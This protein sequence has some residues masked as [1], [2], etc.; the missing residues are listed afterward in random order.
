MKTWVYIDHFKGQAM[1]ASWEA[2]GAGKNL[3]TVTAVIFGQNVEALAKEAFENGAD[4]V[5]LADDVTLADYRAEAFSSSLSKLAAAAS[6]D[7]IFLPTTTRGRE[8]AAMAAIDLKTGV[9]VDV[10]AI[11][12]QGDSIVVTRPIYAGKLL[13]KETCSTRPQ[14]VTLRGRAFPKPATQAGRTSTLTKVSPAMSEADI[15]SKVEG[16]TTAEAGVS[17][18]DASV[19]VSGGRGVS[20]NPAL[21][22]PGGLDEKQT[23]IWRA[24]Q[25]FALVK[26]L[27]SVLGAAV[28]ASRA[29]V[30]AGYVTYSHQVGQTGKVVS[31]DL[32][33]A[34]GISGAIQHLAGMRTSKVIVAVNKDTDA[35]IFK[36]AR[37][38]VVGDL[39][40]ILPALTA[41]FKQRL[42]K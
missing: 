21:T 24:Q 3:G 42:G 22:P 17:L 23:E 9:M 36:V 6:P 31:P 33:I 37:Y 15:K 40:Q 34:N 8:I 39:F 30:D 28:G 41:A 29:A 20:N 12:V 18:I 27:A 11:E 5:L 14:I 16:Y 2:L 25:G 1:P 7:A 13:S 38:G 32:Y 26:E 35:P 10:T 19:I 4:E